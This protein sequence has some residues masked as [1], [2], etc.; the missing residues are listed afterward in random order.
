M[1]QFHPGIAVVTGAGSGIG[2]GTAKALAS[3]GAEVIV[4]DIDLPAAQDAVA[5]I[6]G[7]GGVAM[8][9][10]VDVADTDALEEFA[11]TVR[12]V[13]GVP[14]VV[15][16]NAG[17]VVGGPFLDVPVEDFERIMDIN[18][19]AMIH[20]CRIFGQQMV[21]RGTG[22][23]LVN[24]SSLAAFAPA[25]YCWP[26]SVSKYAV[27]HFS[28]CIRAELA[29]HHIGV[30]AVCPGLIATNLAT[31]A[32]VATVTDRQM[33]IGRTA[34]LKGMALLGANPDGAGRDIVRAI[35]RNTA[36]AP[37]R[38]EAHLARQAGRLFPGIVRA[39]MTV[40]A[41]PRW[42]RLGRKIIDQPRLLDLGEKV[43]SL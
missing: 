33:E 38:P 12:T 42:E 32:Q 31:T 13:H 26:Y 8:A 29:P 28:E 18:L 19:M 15:V 17:I 10:R 35:R 41:H 27:K 25:P 2:R 30:T 16:N 9:Y 1:K 39:G 3:H 24:I 6:R 20:G 7:L 4:A 21:E 5:E 22:G 23:H 14:D 36:V 43:T 11:E 40:V 34:V 37:I